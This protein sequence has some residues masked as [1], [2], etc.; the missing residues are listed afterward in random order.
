MWLYEFFLIII[1]IIDRS[2]SI[3]AG[4]GGFWYNFCYHAN[5][6][7]IYPP[8][9][10][11]HNVASHSLLEWRPWKGFHTYLSNLVMMIRPKGQDKGAS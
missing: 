4:G 11:T 10:L 1:Y 3:Y 9:H 7:G 5:P 8:Q 2:C 6:T